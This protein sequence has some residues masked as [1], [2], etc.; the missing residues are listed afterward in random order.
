M[1]W[2]ALAMYE[3][4]DVRVTPVV[5][6][7]STS[8]VHWLLTEATAEGV[9]E[10]PWLVPDYANEQGK[11]NM[12]IRSLIIESQGKTIIVDT[13][14]GNDKPRAVEYWSMRQGPFLEDLAAAGFPAESI[15]TVLCTHLHVD[16]VGWNTK[17]VDGQW[18]PTFA[19]A[20]Y[21]FTEKEW[22]YWSAQTDEEDVTLRSDSIQPVI[23]AGLVDLVATDHQLTDE[24]W[25]E[26]TPGHTPGHVSVRI[27]S[28]GA[29][30]V[31]T[32]DLA[33]HPCQLARPEWSSSYDVDAPMG[34]A[35][36]HKF[37]GGN[38][39]TDV[40][41]MGTH[42]EPCAGHIHSDGDVWRLEPVR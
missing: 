7:A 23:D 32:G 29:R 26:H 15:D 30:G 16:H 40:L 9:L 20:R 22:E 5:E 12:T 28:N 18:V 10:I 19:N 13:C 42:W 39:D 8:A 38:A 27:E 17:L 3:I 41:V 1:G 34:I 14:L 21:V 25:L 11:V 2:Q 35:T 6:L 36:R 33:H 24:V 4:G 31:I 37:F